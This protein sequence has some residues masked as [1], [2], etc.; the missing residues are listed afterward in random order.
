[1]DTTH[2]TQQQANLQAK[3]H[4]SES[5][6]FLSHISLAESVE[7]HT[8][9]EVCPSLSLRCSHLSGGGAGEEGE[10]GHQP[11][12]T[13]QHSLQLKLIH[14]RRLKQQQQKQMVK[15]MLHQTAYI[16]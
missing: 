6:C 3:D 14:L 10:A 1:M 16:L 8:Q 13:A 15:A 7:E 11:G 12:E 5:G 2:S 9:C 4:L